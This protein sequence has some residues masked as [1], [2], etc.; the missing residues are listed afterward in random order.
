MPQVVPGQYFG[1]GIYD[2]VFSGD[3]TTSTDPLVLNAAVGST[4]RRLDGGAS[5]SFYVR[6]PSGWVA[7]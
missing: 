1:K 6:E 5:T 4:Y 7:K 3:P 2:F